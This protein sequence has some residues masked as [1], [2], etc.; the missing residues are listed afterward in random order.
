MDNLAPQAF[1]HAAE[2]SEAVEYWRQRVAQEKRI[3]S[4]PHADVMMRYELEQV[5]R[6]AAAKA[7]ASNAEGRHSSSKDA[8]GKRNGGPNYKMWRQ[9]LPVPREAGKGQEKVLGVHMQNLGG[10]GSLN[11]QYHSCRYRNELS[12]TW[13]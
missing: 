2:T 9:R 1:A 5:L 11:M 13:G 3:F 10:E 12:G 4:R 8:S 6:K 7:R